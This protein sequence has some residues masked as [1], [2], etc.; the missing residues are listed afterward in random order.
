MHFVF[1]YETTNVVFSFL[2]ISVQM[3]IL[4]HTKDKF[5]GQ[6]K[7]SCGEES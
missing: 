7:T 5:K 2:V 1:C 3:Y 6:D 4:N